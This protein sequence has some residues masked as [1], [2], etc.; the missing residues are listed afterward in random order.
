M[1]QANFFGIAWGTAASVAV[2]LGIAA[3]M[4][5]VCAVHG[6][7]LVRSGIE[8]EPA[9][10]VLFFLS[11]FTLLFDVA[12]ALGRTSMG[13]EVASMQSRYV[14]LLV[15]GM[16]A[17]LLQL[18]ML[19]SGKWSRATIAIFTV[20]LLAGTAKLADSDLSLAMWL[21]DGRLAWR[22]AYLRTGDFDAA[23][24]VSGFEIYPSPEIDNR[25]R[26][27]R[28]HRLNFFADH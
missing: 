21:R 14:T 8:R 13:W 2:G 27:L 19:R 15:P 11:G 7:R 17:I 28:E 22:D 10:A 12:S 26:Y 1:M 6:W 9:S 20:V 4:M 25:L 5:V 3:G 24:R 18:G 16:I 23:G